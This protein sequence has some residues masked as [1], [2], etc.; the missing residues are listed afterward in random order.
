MR[1][2]I[3][4][5]AVL[6]LSSLVAV[7]AFAK[8]QSD[9]KFPM[10]AAAFKAKVDAHTQKARE[11]MEARVAKLPADKA[12]EVRAKFDESVAK[13]NQEVAKVT[14]DGTVTKEE[15][16]EVREVRKSARPHGR[17]ARHG[18]NKKKG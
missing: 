18:K 12:K 1:S 10:P 17:H 2:K 15:A 14:A 16:K 8:G 6:A 9:Q 4:V 3:L 13:V 5:A 11:K 7:P